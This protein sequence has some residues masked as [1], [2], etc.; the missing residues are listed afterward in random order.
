MCG[1]LYCAL[2]TSPSLGATPQAK[3]SKELLAEKPR[4]ALSQVLKIK[5]HKAL[6]ALKARERRCALSDLSPAGP[7]SSW[8]SLF[9]PFYVCEFYQRICR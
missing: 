6:E 7:R 8:C 1:R 2:Y 5:E 4:P 9:L 3:S